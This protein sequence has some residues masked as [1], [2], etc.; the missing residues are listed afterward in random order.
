MN[1]YKKQIFITFLAGI[2]FCQLAA[3]EP[4]GERL[5]NLAEPLGIL[6][7]FAA[8]NNFT[9]M[10]DSIVYQ[11]VAASEFNLVTPE[12]AMKLD[13]IV[14]SEGQYNFG[15]GDILVRFAQAYGMQV[16]GHTLIWHSA[17]PRWLTILNRDMLI[18]AMN[19][20]IDVIL[21]HYKGQILAWD[22]VNE[23]FNEDGTY[24]ASFWNNTIGEDY[25]DRA[26]LR[27]RQADPAAKLFYNDYNIE[28]INQKS[29]GVYKMVRSMI[30]RGIPI[31]GIGIQMHITDQGIDYQS[32]ADNMAR[33][34][35]LGLEIY[36]SE[37][38]V[39]IPVGYNVEID[40]EHQAEIYREVIQRCVAQP[41]CKAIQFWGIPDKYSWVPSVFPGTGVPLLFDDDYNAKPAYYAVQEVLADATPIPTPG[42]V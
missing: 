24:R 41:A 36:I 29:D 16:H 25:I 21:N 3:A 33:F 23:A 34:A 9:V 20:V 18:D 19:N 26:F 10:S 22:V 2:M 6:I 1:H 37:M 15:N 11:Q 7:G 17:Q 12:N 4:T 38:D 5:K 32:F 28:E 30:L 42:P 39:R 8:P 14:P 40:L 13:A 35:A 27:C 31:D